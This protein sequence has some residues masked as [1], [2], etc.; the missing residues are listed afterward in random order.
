MGVKLSELP[1]DY[2]MQALNKLNQQNSKTFYS[3]AQPTDKKQKYNNKPTERR[4]LKF[5]SIREA[6]RFEELRLMEQAG[7]ISHL[8]LQYEYTLKP[9]YILPS[10]ERSR[11]V[12]YKADFRYERDGLVIVEDA[13]GKRTKEYIIKKKLMQEVHGI[14]I[15]EV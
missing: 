8:K 13:K 3:E 15:Q 11:A 12:R 14:T 1:F 10:G 4:G 6:D 5:S 2:Q 9:A 7:Q